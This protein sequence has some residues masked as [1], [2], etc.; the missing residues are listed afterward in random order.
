MALDTYALT[1]FANAYTY[2]GLSSTSSGTVA[3]IEGL[4][5]RASDM[6]E[7]YCNRK[8]AARLYA[9]ERHNGCEQHI[10]YFDNPPVVAVCLDE[11]V[12]TDS[13]KTVTRSD[14]GSFYDDGFS[15]ANNKVLVQ[16]SDDNSGLLTVTAVATGGTTITFSDSITTDSEDNDVTISN[17]RSLW[18]EDDEVDEDNFDV[19][20]DHIYYFGDF[21]E[22]HRNIKITYYGGYTTIPDDLEHACLEVVK[23][24]YEGNENIGNIQSEKLGDHSIEYAVGMRG[25]ADIRVSNISEATKYVLDKYRRI[26]V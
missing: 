13:T 8:F 17:C 24:L 19:L 20:D 21:P 22:G 23:A 10:V 11:L 18:I 2:L 5:N 3:E 14:G 9:K 6:I 7:N 1:T 26:A 15:T 25:N 4:I 12:W 16:N